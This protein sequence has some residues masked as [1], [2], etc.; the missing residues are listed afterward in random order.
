MSYIY[1]FLDS[2]GA[3]IYVGRTENIK[4]RMRTHFGNSSSNG[5]LPKEAYKETASVWYSEVSNLNTSRVYE[6]YYISLLK[7]KYNTEFFSGGDI[8]IELPHLDFEMY[9]IFG[10]EKRQ[11]TLEVETELAFFKHKILSG[12]EK[13]LRSIQIDAMTMKISGFTQEEINDPYVSLHDCRLTKTVKKQI[14]HYE[15]M[16]N[17]CHSNIEKEIKKI[18][19]VLEE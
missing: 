10:E 7:P 19:M 1:K 16:L 18:R 9:D 13:S 5:H 12:L 2:E 14:A 3:T 15:K 17:K 6:L 4:N 11:K 8:G